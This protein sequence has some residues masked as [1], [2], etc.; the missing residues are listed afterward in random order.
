[1][2]GRLCPSRFH[3][4]LGVARAR[5]LRYGHTMI[6]V[7]GA[8]LDDLPALTD[9]YNHYILT[10]PITFDL[11]PYEPQERRTWFDEHAATGRHRLLVAEDDARQV[12]GYA[13][14]SR[15]R[16]KAAYDTTVESSVYCHP[17]ATGRGIGTRLYAAL[18]EAIA[19]QDVHRIVAGATMPNPASVALHQRF[20]FNRV[21]EFAEVG[22]K[23]GQYWNVAWFERPMAL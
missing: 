22:R 21:G 2:R 14:T 7:R 4:G 12:L 16:P 6:A 19:D 17:A 18:F 23:F 15:W 9:I 20:G 1:V 13:T 10:T 8:T 5:R 11:R 3:Y